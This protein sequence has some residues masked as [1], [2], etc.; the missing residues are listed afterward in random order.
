MDTNSKKDN[1]FIADF[2]FYKSRFQKNQKETKLKIRTYADNL[3]RLA[4]VMAKKDKNSSE[5]LDDVDKSSNSNFHKKLLARDMITQTT[6]IQ[7]SIE[8]LSEILDSLHKSSDSKDK[9]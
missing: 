4:K 2:Q 8:E 3:E 9:K 7:K 6:S 5:P 1:P